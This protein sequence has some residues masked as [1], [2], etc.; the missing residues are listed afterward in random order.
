MDTMPTLLVATGNAGK[1][2]EF[3]RMLA[4]RFDV[5]GLDTLPGYV[6]PEETGTTFEANADIKAIAAAK[7]SR[8]LALADDS[9]LEVD[10]LDGA[11]GVYSARYAGPDATDQANNAKLLGALEGQT[12]RS[13]RFRCALSLVAPSGAV[14]ARA[15]GAA[16]GT[17]LYAPQGSGGFGYDPLFMPEGFA[18][19]MAE[20]DP[21]TKNGL[22]HR[23]TALKALC[24]RLDHPEF[25]MTV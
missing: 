13:A 6:A 2:R 24:D 3:R 19:S 20:L 16:H 21:E 8:H 17:I 1:L 14:V 5:I 9:G 25:E 12:V 10:A 18:A 11:P 22:S 23:G 4:G 15:S 7:A